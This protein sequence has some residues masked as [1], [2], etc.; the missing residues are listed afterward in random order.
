LSRVDANLTKA[1]REALLAEVRAEL[2]AFLAPAATEQHDPAG[3]VAAL[4][5]L[6]ER[7]LKRLFAV[8]LL[9][10]KPVREF[11]AGLRGGLRRPITSSLRPKEVAR[12]VRGPIDWTATFA[13]RATSGGDRTQ[14]VVRPARRIF[15]TPENRVLAWLLRRLEAALGEI[16]RPRADAADDLDPEE[17]GWFLELDDV[18][19]QLKA[20]RQTRWLADVKP[21][22]PDRAAL[23]RL[24]VAR[25]SFYR[26]G[27]GG[28]ARAVMRWTENPSDDDL[29]ELIAARYFQPSRDWQLF[30][31]VVALGLAR[32]FAERSPRLRRPRLLVGAADGREPYATY[33]IPGGDEVRLYYQRWPSDAGASA[34]GAARKHH[35][36]GGR[37]PRPD[38]IIQRAG[39]N[40]DA[41]IIELKASRSAGYLGD[42]LLQL[43]G[44]LHDRPKLFAQQPAGWLVGL[45]AGPYERKESPQAA[46]WMLDPADVIEEAL[47]R[48]TS[49]AA[50]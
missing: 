8:H 35:K 1:E 45:E 28:A 13:Y 15:D 22:H 3:D 44:Y 31:V 25:T 12:S 20:A 49:L 16:P 11:L 18:R 10:S 19:R 30:E 23:R 5:N 29:T 37:G 50:G 48:F 40:P 24:D 41:V 34:H 47:K 46:L 38:L 6:D 27:V 33:A 32:G 4:L 39:S 14:Y 21:T 7:D 36:L 42:G 26:V 9:L 43:L 2:P 17:L